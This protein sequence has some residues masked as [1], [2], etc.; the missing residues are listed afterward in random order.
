MDLE[1][2]SLVL[3]E[4]CDSVLTNF[5]EYILCK[6]SIEGIFLENFERVEVNLHLQ[7]IVRLE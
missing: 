5:V 3:V 4:E 2:W 1:V 7:F 6:C